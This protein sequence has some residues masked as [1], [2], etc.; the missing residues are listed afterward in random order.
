MH[1][2]HKS[3]CPQPYPHRFDGNEYGTRLI[4]GGNRNMF[5][6]Q[7]SANGRAG[8]ITTDYIGSP[9]RDDSWTLGGTVTYNLLNKLGLTFDY[10]HIELSSNVPASGFTRDVVALGATWR[11]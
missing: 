5:L 9:R 4:I 8:Y 3:F 7:W 1:F 11:Y 10:Q 2:H 6:E